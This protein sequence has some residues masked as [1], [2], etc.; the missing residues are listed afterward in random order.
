MKSQK[1]NTGVMY[2]TLKFV[3]LLL[4]KQKA[5]DL[6]KSMHLSGSSKLEKNE[7]FA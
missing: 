1:V 2:V 7:S 6:V 4:G 5:V 3:K